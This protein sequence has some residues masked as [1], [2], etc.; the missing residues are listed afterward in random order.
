MPGSG[1]DNSIAIIGMACRFPG[2]VDRPE[3][4]W[5]LL[6]EGRD[7]IEPVPQGRWPDH[8]WDDVAGALAY[9]GAGRAAWM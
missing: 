6:A 3:R 5:Q 4:L 8:A 1:D 9:S 2:G 7:A